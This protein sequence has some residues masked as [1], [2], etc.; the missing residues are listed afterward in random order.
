MVDPAP[1]TLTYPNVDT[2]NSTVIP[3][4]S[5]SAIN[6]ITLSWQ[7]TTA[8]SNFAQCPATGLDLKKPVW[9]TKACDAG[10]LR[11][12]LVPTSNLIRANLASSVLTTFIYPQSG[13]T[14]SFGTLDFTNAADHN[15]STKTALCNSIRSNPSLNSCNF[16]ISGLGGN[17]YYL[18]VRSVYEPNTL[19]VC[20]NS[21]DCSSGINLVGA[22]A[23]VDATGKATDVLRRISARIDVSGGG[24]GV[25][26][27]AIQSK[28]S[29]CKRLDV[30]DTN[31]TFTSPIGGVDISTCAP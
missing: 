22:Q 25:P 23:A 18:R 31:A 26:S 8:G 14:G 21:N 19:L 9:D 6:S 10:V 3:I 27:F 24:E 1:S 28:D 15:G 4:I 17:Q 20:A 16:V 11:V 12:D 2:V 13:A 7:S 5:S 29:I 30:T